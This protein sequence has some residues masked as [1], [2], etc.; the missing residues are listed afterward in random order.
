MLTILNIPDKD[1]YHL[2]PNL[3][4]DYI[5]NKIPNCL[6]EN[7]FHPNTILKVIQKKK[8]FPLEKRKI[9]KD[10]ITK[11]NLSNHPEIIKN[12]HKIDQ[13]NTFFITTGHQLNL[14]GG[15]AF[16]FYKIATAI[17]LSKYFS[18]L[19]PE[20]NFI[21]LFWMATEDD[22]IDEIN[23]FSTSGISFKINTTYKGIV[24]NLPLEDISLSFRKLEK[25]HLLDPI[26]QYLQIIIQDFY[27]NSSDYAHAHHRFIQHFFE[28]HGLLILD[29]SDN[30]F[31]DMVRYVLDEEV[32]YQVISQSIEQQNKILTDHNYKLQAFN[33]SVNFFKIIDNQRIYIE[34]NED[35]GSSTPFTWNVLSRPVIQEFALPNVAYIGGMN[36]LSYWFQSMASFEH[37]QLSPP[38]LVPRSSWFFATHNLIK[39]V[40][41][42][43]FPVSKLIE[44][45]NLFY[46]FLNRWIASKENFTLH[47]LIEKMNIIQGQISQRIEEV[48]STLI[49]SHEKV[50]KH[51]QRELEKIEKKAIRSLKKRNKILIDKIT[52]VRQFFLPAGQWQE[53]KI[54]FLELYLNFGKEKWTDLLIQHSNPFEDI[55]KTGIV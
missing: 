32:N 42:Y 43:H 19:Y 4:S 28:N 11:Q 34:K 48:D 1:I 46:Q 15:P 55:V 26:I 51:Y 5:Q 3:I 22:D 6:F 13:P 25:E 17:H 39:P 52:K 41:K 23:S 49:A 29:P 18:N 53:R 38:L 31:K 30:K 9:L 45:E 24:K 54:H 2:F 37:F 10:I 27:D 12:I 14:F 44:P 35:I 21:P 7:S 8:G 36:E 50:R 16:V 40:T 20:Y 33:R 47:D